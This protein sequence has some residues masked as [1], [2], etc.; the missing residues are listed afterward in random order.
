[1]AVRDVVTYLQRTLRKKSDD[2]TKVTEEIKEL[3]RDMKETMYASEGI[4]LAAPQVGVNQKVIV[5]DVTPYDPDQKLFA[6]INPEIVSGK[7]RWTARKGV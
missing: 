1:M 4:G 5:V 3:I 7:V 6:L 2:V